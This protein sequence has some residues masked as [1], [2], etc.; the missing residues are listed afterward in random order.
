MPK[1]VALAG[2]V[3]GAKLVY[4]LSKVVP[5]DD[6]TVIVNTGD[7]FKRYGL[8][9][10]PDLDTVMYT[11][12][13]LDN[14]MTGWGRKEET[15]NCLMELKKISRDVWF[16][17]GDR[18]IANHM[19][20]SLLLESGMTLTEVTRQLCNRYGIQTKVF[21]M[22]DQKVSTIINTD[23]YGEISF[24]E[25]FVKYHF[26]PKIKSFY[27]KGIDKAKISEELKIRITKSDLVVFC[28]SNPWLSIMPILE[29]SGFRETISSKECIAVSPIVGRQAIKGPAAKIFEEEGITPSAFEVAKLY[30]GIIK[31]IVVDEQN[32]SEIQRIKSL[33]I[34]PFVTDTIMK[35]ELSKKRLA[36]EIINFACHLS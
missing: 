8:T 5:I 29:M 19:E 2:G 23:Q 24:Q 1:I 3:G 20:R 17:L 35:D 33:G 12:G 13:G 27:Y 11:L 18:D 7:D 16:N 32:S 31:S 25:Y 10:C 14:E 36:E 9:I 34:I 22:C 21:P 4:G 6:L 30:K 28:P 26:E 15:W